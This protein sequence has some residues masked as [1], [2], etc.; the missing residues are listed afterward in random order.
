LGGLP[1]NGEKIREG[2]AISRAQLFPLG[3]ASTAVAAE[4][5]SFT[6]TL[7]AHR[8]V[9][10]WGWR[11]LERGPWD[12]QDLDIVRLVFEPF[13]MDIKTPTDIKIMMWIERLIG[14]VIAV[15]VVVAIVSNPETWIWLAFLAVGGIGFAIGRGTA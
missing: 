3:A 15:G 2:I 6:R 9:P 14:A 11:G 13:P 1:E 10:Q 4:P 7:T 8:P 5:Q 12:R